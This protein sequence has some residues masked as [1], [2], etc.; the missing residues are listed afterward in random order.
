MKKFLVPVDFS[1]VTGDVIES[2]AEFARA[3]GGRVM[4]LHV[5]QPPL[6]ASARHALSAAVIE[7]AVA[8]AEEAAEKRLAALVKRLSKIELP[9]DSRVLTGRP[10]DV[11]LKEARRTRADYII[12]GSHGAGKLRRL[13]L[14]STASEVMRSATCG[15][16]L[17]PPENKAYL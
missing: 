6:M 2:A 13:L 11:I 7:E 16:I 12:M 3:F 15:V 5:V 8:I 4:L 14:G 17:L 9:C 1:P 10:A